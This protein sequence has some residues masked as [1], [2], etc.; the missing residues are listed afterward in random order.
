MQNTTLKTLAAAGIALLPA[1]MNAETTIID[2][3]GSDAYV[4]S[5]PT[6]VLFNGYTTSGKSF[7]LTTAFNPSA[8]Y[9]IPTGKSGVFYGGASIASTNG[10]GQWNTT[11]GLTVRNNL[12]TPAFGSEDAIRFYPSWSTTVGDGSQKFYSAVVFKKADFLNGMSTET[13]TFDSSS[14]YSATFALGSGYQT[15]NCR[16]RIIVQ[17]G[18]NWYISQASGLTGGNTAQSATNVTFASRT[19]SSYDPFTSLSAIGA[20]ATPSF[21]NIGAV[22]FAFELS[23]LQSA[24]GGTNGGAW[25]NDFIVNGVSAV[26]EPS[27][28]AVIAGFLVLGGTTVTRRRSR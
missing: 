23:S 1:A 18:S 3:G 19:W 10:T 11:S 12:T 27:S 20:T 2:F 22:G 8:S 7:D 9:S 21:T 15:A 6:H 28:Y 24:N 14:S 5:S 17:D 16:F 13:V 4:A 26:P 25:V